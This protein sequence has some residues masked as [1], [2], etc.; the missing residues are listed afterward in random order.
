[1][2][3]ID[4]A[5]TYRQVIETTSEPP[6]VLKDLEDVSLQ[7]AEANLYPAG[8]SMFILIG[9]FSYKMSRQ[10]KRDKLKKQKKLEE[11]ADQSEEQ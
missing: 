4:N 10:E 7:N 11:Q 6:Q 1:M 9:A 5:H 3:N 2:I 8:V